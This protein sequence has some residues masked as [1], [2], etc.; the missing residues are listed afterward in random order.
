MVII[1]VYNK[2]MHCVSHTVFT[3]QLEKKSKCKSD[4]KPSG[5][6]QLKLKSNNT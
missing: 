3:M 4:C 5:K 1:T 2:H 6:V